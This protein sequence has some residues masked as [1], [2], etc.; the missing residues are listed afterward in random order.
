MGPILVLLILLEAVVIWWVYAQNADLGGKLRTKDSELENMTRELQER[1]SE[2]R[3]LKGLLIGVQVNYTAQSHK[4]AKW[5]VVAV[6]VVQNTGRISFSMT[7][8]GFEVINV[9]Y[10]DESSENWGI[11][12]SGWLNV[13]LSPGESS[14]PLSINISELG[15][16]KEPKAVF[17]RVGVFIPDVGENMTV[18]IRL[19]PQP[20]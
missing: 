20:T 12:G 2:I 3:A 15:F 11:H 10:V 6:L 13:T 14:A 1:Q 16:D 9:T 4:A 7:Q 19:R 5:F 17:V 8:I 18:V